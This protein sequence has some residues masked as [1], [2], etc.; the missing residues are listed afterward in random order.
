MKV[1]SNKSC[2][3]GGRLQPLDNFYKHKRR[4]D[5]LAS[6]CK[7]CVKQ[8][9][10]DHK[11]E[12]LQYNKQYNEDHSEER[13][14]Y[15]KQYRED[16]KEHYKQY[17]EDHKEEKKEYDKQYRQTIQH[18]YSVYEENAK[19]RKLLF[20]LTPEQFEVLTSNVCEYCGEYS[21]NKNYVGVDR[22]NNLAGYVLENCIPCCDICNYMKNN[23]PKDEFFHKVN[24]IYKK[25]LMSGIF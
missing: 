16:R 3:F 11:E 6:Q 18:R 23:L 17:R 15:H 8:Y 7:S 5:G 24:K 25:H 13:K 12:R 9:N 1:C 20:L 19:Q 14:E 2:V 10:K 22:L 21:E 4:K